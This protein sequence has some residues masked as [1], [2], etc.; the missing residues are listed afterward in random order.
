MKCVLFYH[1]AL[2]DWNHG[3]AHFLRGVAAELQSRGHDVV[4]YEVSRGGLGSFTVDLPP[5]LAVETVGTDEG[6]K[7]VV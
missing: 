3:N 4:I 5:G 7:S 1:S 2:S 6:G